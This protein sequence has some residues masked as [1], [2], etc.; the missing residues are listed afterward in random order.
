LTNFFN[1]KRWKPPFLWYN[2]Q[3]EGLVWLIK[4]YIENID[5]IISIM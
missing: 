1:N 4:F 5:L 2:I 3:Q